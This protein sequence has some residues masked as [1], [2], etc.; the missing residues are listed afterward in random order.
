M[1]RGMLDNQ[2]YNFHDNSGVSVPLVGTPNIP[3]EETWDDV[4]ILL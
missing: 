1:H 4:S 3:C 2:L